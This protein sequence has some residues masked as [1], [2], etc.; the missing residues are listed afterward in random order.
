MRRLCV[1]A[2]IRGTWDDTA[3]AVLEDLCFSKPRCGPHCLFDYFLTGEWAPGMTHRQTAETGAYTSNQRGSHFLTL[4]LREGKEGAV[5]FRDFFCER[6]LSHRPGPKC[7]PA[8][9]DN[10]PRS[11]SSKATSTRLRP[12]EVQPLCIFPW[13]FHQENTNMLTH[14]IHFNQSRIN[15]ETFWP[16]ISRP[17]TV[18]FTWTDTTEKRSDALKV[19][20]TDALMPSGADGGAEVTHNV[21]QA[22]D[23][24]LGQPAVRSKRTLTPQ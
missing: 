11:S 24:S 17:R 12:F 14:L 20:R 10:S 19:P 7:N 13:L 1:I 6:H 5:Q 23:T 8:D 9:L 15:F 21:G 18:V 16:V 22:H 4:H 2:L 3:P